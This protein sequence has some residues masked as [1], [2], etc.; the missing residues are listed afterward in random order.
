MR[1]HFAKYRGQGAAV[2]PIP[3]RH[4]I[5]WS[6][7]GACVAI[8]A[9]AWLSS[10]AGAPFI[11]APFGASCV[12]IFGLPNSP[13]AQPRNLVL[14]HLIATVVGLIVMEALGVGWLSMGIAV[15]S[16]IALMQ[17]TRTLHAPAGATPLVVMLENADWS[18]LFTP[19]L[20]GT[21]VLLVVGLVANNLSRERSYPEYW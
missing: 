2:P 19:V 18:F 16:A 14:G 6:W 13:L 8:A 17:M 15:A 5:F 1:Q 21:L 11:M 12:L 9:I 4:F 3:N 10:A 7:L 20:S